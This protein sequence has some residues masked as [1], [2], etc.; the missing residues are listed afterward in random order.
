[1]HADVEEHSKKPDV[2]RDII[3]AMT[4][5]LQPRLELFARGNPYP[6]FIAWGNEV[7]IPLKSE[8]A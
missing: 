6:G 7:A 2:F 3:V 4:P 1:V 8:A 5:N